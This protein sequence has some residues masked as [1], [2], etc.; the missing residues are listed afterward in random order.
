MMRAAIK[1]GLMVSLAV[2]VIAGPARA[3]SGSVSDQAWR[4]WLVDVAPLMLGQEPAV[5]KT[6]PAEDRSLFI[7]AFW[8]RRNPSP[9]ATDNPVKTEVEGRIRSADKRFREAGTGAWNACG[10]TFLLLGAPSWTTN[11]TTAAHSASSDPLVTMRAQDDQVGE[12]WIYRSNPRL[13][14]S[15]EGVRFNF[16]PQCEPLDGPAGQRLIAAVA[17]TFLRPQR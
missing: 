17:A 2:I 14:K 3:Q 12:V 13:P 5:A 16:T 11:A 9:S 7:E 6:V 4:Q 15:A 1:I 10:R 8:T